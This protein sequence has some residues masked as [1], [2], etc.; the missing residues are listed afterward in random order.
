MLFRSYIRDNFSNNR[1]LLEDLK[2]IIKNSKVELDENTFN[3]FILK[4]SDCNSIVKNNFICFESDGK[5]YMHNSVKP[6]EIKYYKYTEQNP[7][8]FRGQDFPFT[9]IYPEEVK[10]E[11]IEKSLILFKPAVLKLKKEIEDEINEKIIRNNIIRYKSKSDS[12]REG[13]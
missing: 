2:F 7:I 4:L 9:I 12:T 13:N 3:K 10:N 5:Y 1:L 11:E 8:I 6:S